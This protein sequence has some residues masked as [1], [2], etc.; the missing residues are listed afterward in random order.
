MI[1]R[2]VVSHDLA[3]YNAVAIRWIRYVVAF[4]IVG[5]NL[6]DYVSYIHSMPKAFSCHKRYISTMSFPVNWQ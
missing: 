2:M 4:F 3:L 1:I 6:L 5:Q